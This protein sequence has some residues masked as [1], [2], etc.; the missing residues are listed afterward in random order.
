LLLFKPFWIN[1]NSSAATHGTRQP[2]AQHVPLIFMGASFKPGRYHDH[3][4]PSDL[5]PTLGSIVGI[6]LTHADGKVQKA[7]VK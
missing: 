6:R 1:T 4:T 2:Y 3:A 5:A 7:A